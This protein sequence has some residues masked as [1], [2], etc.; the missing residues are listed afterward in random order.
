MLY[1]RR[2]LEPDTAGAGAWRGGLAASMAFTAHGVRETE[3]LIMTHGLEVPN[4]SGLFGGYPGSCVTQKFCR[5][6]DLLERQAMGEMP[7]GIDELS[8]EV[9]TMGPKPGLTPMRPGDVFETSWQGGGGLGDP[10][11]RDPARVA[12]DV[13]SRH[14]SRPVAERLYGV[15]LLEAGRPDDAAT[16]ALR[17][18]M[19]QARLRNAVPPRAPQ[20]GKADGGARPIGGTMQFAR[21]AGRRWFACQCGQPLAEDAGNW[22]DGASRRTVPADEIG[23]GIVLHEKLE[24]RQWLC[25]AC[26]SSLSVDV[27]EKGAPDIH[28]IALAG[29][30]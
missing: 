22:R 7:V 21:H 15:V 25:S 23:A 16:A 14:T 4:S 28:D 24:L 10:L 5:G 13:D 19:R 8:G 20:T 18:R 12:D 26:G 2:R 11:D 17:A 3:A 9:V 29:G 27:M 6:S 30:A 1:L